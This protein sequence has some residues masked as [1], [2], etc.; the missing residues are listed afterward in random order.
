MVVLGQ[1]DQ[2]LLDRAALELHVAQLGRGLLA[3]APVALFLGHR[4]VGP[5]DQQ[6][7]WL[8]GASGP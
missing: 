6:A 3:H 5:D 7:G 4:R 2:R 1:V 8:D